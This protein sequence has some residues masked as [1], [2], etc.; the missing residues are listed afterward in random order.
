MSGVVIIITMWI[1][2]A[3]TVPLVVITAKTGG[4]SFF[5]NYYCY[6]STG[7]GYSYYTDYKYYIY[8]YSNFTCYK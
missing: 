7:Y 1:S 4:Y 5:Y 6:Y 2:V 3:T 8:T